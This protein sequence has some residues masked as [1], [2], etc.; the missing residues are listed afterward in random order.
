MSASS[1]WERI[2]VGLPELS[3]RE[4]LS[5]EGKGSTKWAA[6]S[7]SPA[8]VVLWES[9]DAVVVEQ[10]ASSPQSQR[11]LDWNF[12]E[13]L[14]QK[15][16][17]IIMGR[18]EDVTACTLAVLSH[19]AKVIQVLKF[20]TNT[21]FILSN[22]D[23]VVSYSEQDTSE[24]LQ[25][26]PVTPERGKL[27]QARKELRER[28]VANYLFPME[29]KPYWKFQFLL[30]N[31]ST[32]RMVEQ[33][34]MPV[35]YT[36]EDIA[37]QH[38]LPRSWSDEKQKVFHL[39]RQVYGQMV[40]S[41]RKY[42]VIH[43][44]ERWW[45]CQ[46][47]DTGDLMI[48]R[49]FERNDVSPSVFQAILAL[50]MM[51]DHNMPYAGHNLQSPT[52][53]MP[54]PFDDKDDDVY[55]DK[56]RPRRFFFKPKNLLPKWGGGKR[57]RGPSG[58]GT[59]RTAAGTDEPHDVANQILM[60]DCQVEDANENVQLLSNK[61]Y[62]EML[63]KLQRYR[64]HTHVTQEMEQEA[65]IYR[66]LLS[67]TD[68]SSVWDAIPAF[69]G[70]SKHVGVA[71]ICLSREGDDFEDIGLENLSVPLKRSAIQS[72]KALSRVGILH[73]DIALRN[74]VQSREDPDHAKIVDFGRARL[75]QDRT[76]LREQVESLK[77]ILG[78]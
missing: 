74:I 47:T 29:T 20:E 76:A 36:R 9:F 67:M 72:M 13:S 16:P 75:S 73:G 68:S 42:G 1:L 19:F 69:H 26:R 38:P 28:M 6:H 46:R 18:E 52:P 3:Y 61:K 39:I 55:D 14:Q 15:A 37:K 54:K 78:L 56:S 77:V 66:K 30:G 2:N 27:A 65:L 44:Y 17:D 49:S 7:H 22:P 63:I 43:I 64:E 57:N 59:Q 62:P 11:T 8:G 40:E 25:N 31:D 10:A 35:G 50:A 24:T 33:W 48:S 4:R 51:P 60:H 5:I 23:I 70:F 53:S 58:H 71:M 45:F 32:E 34:E 21:C 41:R 12:A